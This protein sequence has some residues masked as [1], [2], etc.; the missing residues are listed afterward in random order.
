MH[1]PHSLA[2]R[3]PSH[4]F[5]SRKESGGSTSNPLI[6]SHDDRNRH[7]LMFTHGGQDSHV[8]LANRAYAS[9]GVEERRKT[10]HVRWLKLEAEVVATST[11][12]AEVAAVQ[13]YTI[14]RG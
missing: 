12:A 13:G 9:Y 5:V 4:C 14:L 1:D 3:R 2:K 6:H 10:W 7:L 8:Q 11:I